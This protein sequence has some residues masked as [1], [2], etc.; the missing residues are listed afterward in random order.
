MAVSSGDKN[1]GRGGKFWT[2]ALLVLFVI[3]VF[4]YTLV[5]RM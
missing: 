4:G 1:S 3:A 5:S 2:A